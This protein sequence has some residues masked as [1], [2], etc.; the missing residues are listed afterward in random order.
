M[1]SI[2]CL[3]I[4]LIAIAI[5]PFKSGAWGFFAHK[6]INRLA[7]Y[8]LPPGMLVLFKPGL[9][10][11]TEH[12]CDPDKRRYMIPAEGPRHY[13]DIDLYGTYPYPELPRNYRDALAKFGRDSLQSRGILPWHF[14]WMLARLTKAFDTTDTRYILKIATELGHYVADAHVPLHACSNH[15]GQFSQQEGIHGL[16]ESKIP[17]LVADADFN[18]WVGKARYIDDPGSFIWKVI[19]ESAAAADTV[20]RL[21]KQLSDSLPL[22]QK[23]SF[24]LRSNQLVYQYSEMYTRAY[25]ELLGDMVQ[26]RMRNA[27]F[28]VA[29][30]WYT[31]WINAGQPVLDKHFSPT[32]TSAEETEIQ[33]LNQHWRKGKIFGRNHE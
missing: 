7:V 16:W 15:N 17:E 3:S 26:R 21:E 33:K 10:Y 31:A 32:A 27:I 22:Q 6:R 9:E 14:E 29:S 8:S 28:A 1:K 4:L 20:L 19:L 18:Y 25:Q 12:A 13:I 5:I 2:V 24:T 23:Y 30:C 11:V